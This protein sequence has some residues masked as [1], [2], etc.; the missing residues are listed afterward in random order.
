[1]RRLALIVSMLWVF[2]GATCAF[3]ELVQDKSQLSG[4]DGLLLSQEECAGWTTEPVQIYRISYKSDGNKVT[5]FVLRPSAPGNYPLLVYCRGGNLER[6]KITQKSIEQHLDLYAKNYIVVVSQLRGNDG[7]T[8][9]QDY[10]G[11]DIDDTMNIYA[12]GKSL[13]GFD[14][15]N[16]F[17]DGISEGGIGVYGSLAKGLPAKAAVVVSGVADLEAWQER[18]RKGKSKSPVMKLSKDQVQE[19]NP[20]G[21]ASKL[22]VP[23]LILDGGKDENVTASLHGEKMEQALKAA[24]APVTRKFF[25]DAGHVLAG[26]RGQMIK[27][28]INWFEEHRQN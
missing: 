18:E 1:M 16:V 19:R 11:G 7:G 3:G 20:L 4:E 24:G 5:G 12:L 21:Y 22:Q 28:V 10:A 8:G 17:I 2:A 26:A 15:K 23:L 6:Y 13:E 25:P 14:G 27:D 9:H